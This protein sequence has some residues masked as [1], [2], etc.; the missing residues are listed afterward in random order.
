MKKTVLSLMA[1]AAFSVQAAELASFPEVADAVSHGQVL[2]FVW[3]VKNC[4]SEMPLPDVTTSIQPNAIMLI[5]G[6]LVTASDRHFTLNDPF[7][8]GTPAFGYSKFE[9]TADGKAALKITLMRA[10][11]Y[12][13]V[14]EY[15]IQCHLGNGLN[16]FTAG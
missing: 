2:S 11:D 6:Q 1:A 9:L 7:L 14:K 10:A 5:A 12:S 13:K 4:V 3:S 15:S 16:I 8:P